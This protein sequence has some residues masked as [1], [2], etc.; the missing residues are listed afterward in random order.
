MNRKITQKE[1]EK[2]FLFCE[3]HYVD[4]YDLQIEL[5]D[6][7][8][9]AIEEQWEKD[10]GLDLNKALLNTFGKF[11]ITGFGK[12]KQQ[13]EKEL[14]Q[15]YNRLLWK[16]L[17]E[18]Y[19][20]PKIIMTLTFTIVLFTLFQIEENSLW[21]LVPYFTVITI[22]I[23]FYFYK[24]F[25]R[26]FKVK[27]KLGKSFMILNKLKEVQFL[28][29]LVVLIPFQIANFWNIFNINWIGNSDLGLFII[30]LLIVTFTIILYGQLMFIPKK[31]KEH[32]ME[33]FGEFAV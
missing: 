20:L 32:F 6:H 13:K 12:I 33:Q 11:G 31:I 16:Y 22:A 2:L 9:S 7:L 24:I 14:R 17:L 18:F 28:V 30:A 3:K 26:E 4:Y 25:P 21:I 19:R 8:A 10:Y 15:K 29:F 23:I 5:V 27:T 1:T